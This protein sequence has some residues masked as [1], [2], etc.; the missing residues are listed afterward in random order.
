M[1]AG[2]VQSLSASITIHTSQ[3]GGVALDL[4]ME[5]GKTWPEVQ[6]KYAGMQTQ[7]NLEESV[8]FF[9]CQSPVSGANKCLIQQDLNMLP[10]QRWSGYRTTILKFF[11]GLRD[12]T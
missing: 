8:F 3:H 12:Q 4:A 7:A 9:K 10:N 6:K 2:I 5:K 1:F 11:C